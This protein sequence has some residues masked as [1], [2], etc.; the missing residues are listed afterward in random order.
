MREQEEEIRCLNEEL[1]VY[2]EKYEAALKDTDLL[3]HL[4]ESRIIEQDEN[5]ISKQ[6]RLQLRDDCI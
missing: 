2:K 6:T 5:P 3:M 4:Y 1:D